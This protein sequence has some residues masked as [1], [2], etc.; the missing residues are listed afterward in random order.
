MNKLIK[1][2]VMRLLVE[3]RSYEHSDFILIFIF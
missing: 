3:P 2:H 1:F